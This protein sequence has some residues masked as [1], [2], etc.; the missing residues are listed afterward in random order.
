MNNK[1]LVVD[2]E[3][4]G[5]Y[6]S[7]LSIAAAAVSGFRIKDRFYGAVR[8]ERE[9]IK[10]EWVREN[11]FD[12]LKNAQTFYDDEESLLRAF[13]EF[14]LRYCDEYAVAADVPYPV[15]A[16]LFMKC[17][18]FDEEGREAHSPFPIYDIESMLAARGHE[19]L[20]DRKKLVDTDIELHD[21]MNDVEISVRILE[22]IYNGTI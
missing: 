2:A 12:H 19:K 10:S 18:A 14:Y 6:G 16:G 20:T 9:E 8:V 22:G 21:A 4:D 7:V 15:E 17:T 5:L 1:F 3:T 11:V 13:W